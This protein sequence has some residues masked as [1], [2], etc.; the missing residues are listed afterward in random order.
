L[1][2]FAGLLDIGARFISYAIYIIWYLYGDP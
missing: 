2:R 1:N